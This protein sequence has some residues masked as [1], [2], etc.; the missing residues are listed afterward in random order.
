MTPGKILVAAGLLAL[1]THPPASANI[2]DPIPRRITKGSFAI[3]LLTVAAGLVGPNHLTDAGDGTDRKFVVDRPGQI[4][5]IQDGQL[6]SRPF[7][8][9][10]DRTI[11]GVERGLFGLAFHPGFADPNSPGFRTLYTYNSEEVSNTVDFPLPPFPTNSVAADH[12]SVI[13][14]WKVSANDPNVVDLGTR[15]EL[16]RIAQPQANHNGGALAFSPIDGNLYIALGDGG[17][18]NDMGPGHSPQGNGQNTGNILGNILRIDPLNTALTSGSAN[19]ISANGQYRI[20]ADNPFV[21]ATPGVD[22]IFAS[23]FRNPFRMSFDA[24]DGRL[25]VGDVGQDNIEEVDI[26]TRGGNYGWRL[27]E[28]SFRFDPATGEVSLDLN[29]DPNLIDPVAE[30]DHDEGLSII[31]GFVYRGTAIPELQGR[32]IFGDFGRFGESPG[33]L[34]ETDLITGQIS[35]L[36]IGPDD[37]SLGASLLGF[38]QDAQNELYVLAATAPNASQT[39]GGIV[40]RIVPLSVVPEPTSGALMSLGVLGLLGYVKRRGAATA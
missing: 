14:E 16:L 34:F 26:V 1:T 9:I 24:A 18:A 25:I 23:G 39:S 35:E 6:A 13:A 37:R 10:S 4:R 3:D 30:Y 8:D 29:P 28:G 17:A 2:V 15:R 20:P 38:G 33:R 12:N 32:Y 11:T 7:L 5:L 36:I 40:Y 21:G 27:K 19:P 31:G 22:E